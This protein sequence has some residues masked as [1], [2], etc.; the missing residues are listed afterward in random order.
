M[1]TY[2]RR[3]PAKHEYEVQGGSSHLG[4]F[5]FVGNRENTAVKTAIEWM[6]EAW[7]DEDHVRLYHTHPSPGPVRRYVGVV[8]ADGL[9]R[10]I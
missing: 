7:P 5:A 8:K 1:A 3:N 2:H 9:H 4:P 10:A 6:T